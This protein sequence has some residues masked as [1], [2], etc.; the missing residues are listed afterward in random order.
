RGTP[1]ARRANITQ[2]SAGQSRFSLNA[3]APAKIGLLRAFLEMDFYGAGSTVHLRHAFG[4]AGPVTAGYT[5]STL[6]DLTSLPPTVAFTAPSGA[7]F[8]PHG[9]IRWSIPLKKGVDL[10]LALEAPR[11]DVTPTAPTDV[12]ILSWPDAVA[13]LRLASGTKVHVQFGA[14]LRRVGVDHLNGVNEEVI[15]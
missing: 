2:F 9:I 8:A 5:W 14:I 6:M 10:A 3:Q 1:A 4:Q 15:G 13:T 12:T 11:D 7:I